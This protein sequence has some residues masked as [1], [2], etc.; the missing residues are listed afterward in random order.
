MMVC[1]PFLLIFASAVAIQQTGRMLTVNVG[2]F[3]SVADG[4]TKDPVA[5]QTALDRFPFFGV[6]KVLFTSVEY[7]TGADIPRRSSP[8]PRRPAKYCLRRRNCDNYL[9]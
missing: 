9:T 1:L 8:R 2:D 7:L 4:K 6:R 3:G 5:V